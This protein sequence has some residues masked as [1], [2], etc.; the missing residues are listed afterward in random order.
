[1]VASKEYNKIDSRKQELLELTAKIEG[2]EAQLRQNTALATSGGGGGGTNAASG[3]DRS[4]ILGTSV[5]C[6]RVTKQGASITIDDKTYWWCEKHIDPADR[7][8]GM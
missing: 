8:N 7:W 2:L 6:W 4:M 5:E 1:M 3:F